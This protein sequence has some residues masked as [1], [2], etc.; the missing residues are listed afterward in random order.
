MLK[1]LEQRPEM[2]A[3]ADIQLSQL[4]A[5]FPLHKCYG[6]SKSAMRTHLTKRLAELKKLPIASYCTY[7]KNNNVPAGKATLSEM[8]QE[9]NP[10]VEGMDNLFDALSV[11]GQKTLQGEQPPMNQVKLATATATP[12]GTASTMPPYERAKTA[13]SPAT[14]SPM[15]QSLITSFD[16][17]GP[18]DDI[19]T[20]EN[21]HPSW[22]DFNFPERNPFFQVRKLTERICRDGYSAEVL[23]FTKQVDAADILEHHAWVVGDPKI[24]GFESD[25]GL[26][27][28][29][30]L[31]VSWTFCQPHLINNSKN[32]EMKLCKTDLGNE[33]SHLL[34]V[35][36][37]E[38]RKRRYKLMIVAGMKLDPRFLCEDHRDPNLIPACVNTVKVSKKDN[39]CGKK[40][41]QTLIH[42]RVAIA[43]TRL[44]EEE[45]KKKSV[46]EHFK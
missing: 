37:S 16:T 20:K 33:K 6:T 39:P 7:L 25:I 41:Y 8:L 46:A 4:I 40:L 29:E 42:W 1:D 26:I 12:I 34:A 23:Q 24:Y 31:V 5:S 45:A 3:L 38:Q 43:D 14:G 2:V 10:T 36:K 18:G 11:N 15:L 21:P 22:V 27:L 28:C 30:E 17:Q 9:A 32:N 35:K 19:G 13:T 44:K